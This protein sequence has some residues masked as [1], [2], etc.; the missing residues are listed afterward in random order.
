MTIDQRISC[1]QRTS[2]ALRRLLIL[3]LW[4][5]VMLPAGRVGAEPPAEVQDAAYAQY[6]GDGLRLFAEGQFGPAAQNLLRAYAMDA[7]ARTLAMAISAYDEMGFCDAVSRQ[8]LLYQQAHPDAPPLAIS[9]CKAPGQLVLECAG[10]RPEVGEGWVRVND[11]FDVKCGRD[12]ALPA[13]EHHLRARTRT[14]RGE[15]ARAPQSI[16]V[17]AGKKSTVL[18]DFYDVPTRWEAAG[19]A[20]HALQTLDA[21]V[22]RLGQPSLVYSVI[23]GEDGIYQ[24]YVHPYPDAAPEFISLPLRP[25]VLR[26]CDAGQRLD[27]RARRCV[28]VDALAVPKFD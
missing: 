27:L 22:E 3:G 10:L 6:F 12:I 4:A 18:L 24:V 11:E 23:L 16:T 1:D 8:T 15:Q 19:K 7:R 9:R 13:G 5:G 28:P 25:E 26:L 17:T 14:V 20:A 21:R 2:C